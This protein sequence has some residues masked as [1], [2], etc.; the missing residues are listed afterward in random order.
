MIAAM[1]TTILKELKSCQGCDG[2]IEKKNIAQICFCSKWS[3]TKGERMNLRI[4]VIN[5]WCYHVELCAEQN[6]WVTDGQMLQVQI[7]FYDS[8]KKKSFF[9]GFKFV[10]F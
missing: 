2:P 9:K 10:F 5:V 3:T 1:F 6:G 4:I 7:C 8:F